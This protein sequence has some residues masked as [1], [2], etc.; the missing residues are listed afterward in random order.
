MRGRELVA[1]LIFNRLPEYDVP[2]AE[3]LQELNEDL[4][5]LTSDKLEKDFKGYKQVLAFENYD[6][7]SAVEFAALRLY[8][9]KPYRAV[10]A[11]AERDI[12]RAA[13]IRE[14]LGIPGQ[15]LKS[16]VAFRN[17]VKMKEILGA[18]GVRVPAYARVDSVVDLYRFIRKHG[19]PV[20]VK[21]EDGMGSRDT[22]VLFSDQDT[23]RYLSQGLPKGL[24]VEEFIEGE[25]YHIDGLVLNGDL[26]HIWPSKYLNDCLAFHEGK[27][28]GSFLLEPSN[29]LT[30]RLRVFVSA[31]L[32]ILPTPLHTPFHAEVFH[33]PQDELVLCEIACRTGGSRISEEFR[34]AFGLDLTKLA[35]QAQ[36]GIRVRIP[37]QIRNRP[38]PKTQYGFIGLPPKKGLFE[39]GPTADELPEWVTEYRLMARPG[40]MYDGPHTSVDYVATFLVKGNSEQQVLER[41]EAVA[42]LFHRKAK[43]R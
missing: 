3:W 1:I 24:E 10:I 9:E 29:P 12:L 8:E 15:S 19:Y 25:M 34:Q 6:F 31:L 22:E 27:Y 14:Y 21:P 30:E 35:V 17:K 13:T 2:Y 11:T 42:D 39:S 4:I 16:A 7:N 37:D 41:L 28:L 40:N 33:T 23:I 5:L 36:C 18:A 32:K 43:W 26:V 38:E 20:V